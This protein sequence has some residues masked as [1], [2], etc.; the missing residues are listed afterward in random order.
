VPAAA[1]RATDAPE[2]R[3]FDIRLR[4]RA[5]QAALAAAAL[6][7]VLAAF[8]PLSEGT[9]PRLRLFDTLALGLGVAG[10]AFLASLR[11]RGTAEQLAFYAFL[12]LSL[13]GLGQILAPLGFPAWPALAVLLGAVAVAE[14]RNFGLALAALAGALAFADAW[15]VQPLAWRPALATTLGYLALVLALDLAQ[16]GEKKGLEQARGELLRVLHGIDQLEEPQPPPAGRSVEELPP[17]PLRQVNEDGRRARQAE[18]AATLEQTLQRIVL[19]AK[20]AVDAHAV[21][22]FDLDRERDRA[23]L[24]AYAGPAEV[25]TDAT[26]PLGE[27]P[28]GFVKD[29]GQSFYATDFKKMLWNLP[30]YRREV[31]VGSV[32]AVPV[33]AQD[34]LVGVLVAD[35]LEVQSLTGGEPAVL[36]GFAGLIGSTILAT[37][38]ASSREE[39]HTEFKAVYDVSADMVN[40]IE[41]PALRRKLLACARNLVAAEGGAVV[42]VDRQ[43]TRYTLDLAFGWVREFEGREVGLLERTWTAWVLKRDELALL[44]DDV[45]GQQDRM[46]VLVLDEGSA[47]A[48]SLLAVAL[49]IRKTTLGALILTG[50]RGAFDSSAQRVLTI[51]ANQT[52]GALQAA[53]LVEAEKQ[54]ALRDGLTGLYNR[55]AFNE[56]LDKAIGREERQKG[57]FALLLVD[58]DH[59][60]KLNDTF[61]HPAGD[62]ALKHTAH[63]LEQHL[64]KG[65]QA[66]RF[67]GEEFALI[68]PATDAAGAQQIAERLRSEVEKARIIAEG[69]RLS[70]T[71]SVGVAVWPLHGK[72]EAALVAAADRALYAAKQSGRN[73]V[74]VAAAGTLPLA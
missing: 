57:G 54:N 74:V 49:R 17:H 1:P 11:G 68:L 35:R 58:I 27:D 14:R 61:G 42:M 30:Y 22:Y 23:F 2:P 67:G 48:E 31:K 6:L 43:Q 62:A 63:V 26:I 13:D 24:R 65:D 9:S 56:S 69:A 40:V 25:V 3:L 53:L 15:Q 41:A 51:L 28:F 39:M 4:W 45:H 16:R 36:D 10:T 70:V 18:R 44:L 52:A 72:D 47:R 66:A 55:R 29:R 20:N 59:F 60:K 37:R 32:L 33:A 38:A 7:T 5:G 21:L 34:V 12:V 71:I 50:K 64:R 46:P 19:L 73:R 8:R